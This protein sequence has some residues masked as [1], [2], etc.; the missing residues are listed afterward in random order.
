MSMMRRPLKLAA[1]LSAS[2]LL[3]EER[4]NCRLRHIDDNKSQQLVKVATRIAT[5]AIDIALGK[6]LCDTEPAPGVV[7]VD[8]MILLD[9]GLSD[10]ISSVWL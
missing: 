10:E 5:R 3:C 9:C 8:G 1:D 2:S 7:R 6:P 4:L